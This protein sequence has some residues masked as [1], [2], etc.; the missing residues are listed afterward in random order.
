MTEKSKPT[1]ES[2]EPRDLDTWMPDNVYIDTPRGKAIDVLGTV[3]SRESAQLPSI[4]TSNLTVGDRL[5]LRFTDGTQQALDV[6]GFLIDNLAFGS[7]EVVR[8]SCSVSDEK[9]EVGILVGSSIGVST[10]LT[11]GKIGIGNY[12]I[13]TLPDSDYEE[14]PPIIAD[15]N[16]Q[17][18]N[19]D[20]QYIEVSLNKR[21]NEKPAISDQMKAIRAQYETFVEELEKQGY[22][23]GDKLRDSLG[24][25][26]LRVSDTELIFAARQGFGWGIVPQDEIHRYDLLTG[27]LTG[28]RYLP[29]LDIAQIAVMQNVDP[30][31]FAR[32]CFGY[33]GDELDWK[34]VRSINDSGYHRLSSKYPFISYTWLN[35]GAESPVINVIYDPDDSRSSSDLGH[36]NLPPRQLNISF[37][38]GDSDVKALK[39]GWWI[40][41]KDTY[42]RAVEASTKITYFDEEVKV[43]YAGADIT[44]PVNPLNRTAD[45]VTALRRPQ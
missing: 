22:K 32:E 41:E 36:S 44:V 18:Q 16:L 26:Y 19:S 24:D 1:N 45:I 13:T 21:S 9:G 42:M 40:D 11:P 15:I 10:M 35:A 31:D 17:T 43:E 20:G 12:L 23:F 25:E 8:P 33:S 39:P 27:D 37:M 3:A 30:I 4:T 6:Q 28:I 38:V 34:A 29:G 2:S 5:K 7:D 14:I